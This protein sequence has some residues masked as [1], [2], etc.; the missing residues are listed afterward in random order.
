MPF[1]FSILYPNDSFTSVYTRSNEFTNST[2]L[3]ECDDF[4]S[5]CSPQHF[6]SS[7]TKLKLFSF[8]VILLQ[9][10]NVSK[11]LIVT[12]LVVS[13]VVRCSLTQPHKLKW[14]SSGKNTIAFSGK[15]PKC[16]R[17][18]ATNYHKSFVSNSYPTIT[19]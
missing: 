9:N 17:Q 15:S 4:F 12:R 5:N 6:Q 8:Q 2:L 19:S 11:F 7:R 18:Q 16:P 1:R 14:A 13:H 3:L 10:W